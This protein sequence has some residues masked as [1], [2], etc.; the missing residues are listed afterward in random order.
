MT[1]ERPFCFAR[2]ALWTEGSKGEGRIEKG[3][4]RIEN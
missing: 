2:G 3:E 4:G 1:P